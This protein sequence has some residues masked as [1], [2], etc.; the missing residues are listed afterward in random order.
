MKII[1]S[2]KLTIINN[3]HTISHWSVNNWE[4][5]S[6][7]EPWKPFYKWFFG[8]SSEFFIMRAENGESLLRRSTI[9]SFDVR[10]YLDHNYIDDNRLLD[11]WVRR[12]FG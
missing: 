8:R 5:D 9:L 11:R 1:K 2:N 12:L 7:I 6:I 3:D 10:V 4:G